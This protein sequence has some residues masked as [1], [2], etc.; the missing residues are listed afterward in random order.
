MKMGRYYGM[1]EVYYPL[2][3]EPLVSIIT[4]KKE[5]IAEL[6]RGMT[7]RNYEVI[8]TGSDR[9]VPEELNKATQKATGEIILYLSSAKGAEKDNWLHVLAANVM[10]EEV[11]AAGPKLLN[12]DGNV[13]SAG[14]V[15]GLQGTA[16]GLFVGH[17]KDSN[18][19]FNHAITQQC[20]SAIAVN[21]MAIKKERFL[22]TNGWNEKLTA[23][24][25]GIQLCLELQKNGDYVIFSPYAE[26][27]V[28][29]TAD[30]P[31]QILIED[32]EFQRQYGEMIKWD[33]YYNRNFDRNGEEFT[34]AY[35]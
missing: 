12:T 1:Y 27:Y 18:G 19:Y 8:E 21:G 28:D 16:S 32:E 9:F 6:L 33:P 35:D 25:A 30:S 14:L 20:M 23:A 26:L 10:R 24:Q 29:E 2:E 34:L 4:T 17:E 15:V 11:A 13:L 7:Y 22:K 5:A 3:K 31:H